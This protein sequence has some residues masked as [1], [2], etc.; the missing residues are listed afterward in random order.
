MPPP[1]P[2]PLYHF[3]S[4]DRVGRIERGGLTERLGIVPP[5]WAPLTSRPGD[6]VPPLPGQPPGTAAVAAY[7]GQWLTDDPDFRQEWATRS[8]IPHDRTA[9]RV[10]VEVPPRGTELLVAWPDFVGRKR[11]DQRWPLWL[12]DFEGRTLPEGE[13]GAYGG[14]PD[15]SRWW[16]YLGL[17]PPQWLRQWTRRPERIG[18]GARRRVEAA[19]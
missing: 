4:P 5:P 18:A 15:P 1:R 6:P 11:L 2:A 8:T 14:R 9:W 13:G 10:R 7:P 12:A 17:V 16:V 3:T 19:R